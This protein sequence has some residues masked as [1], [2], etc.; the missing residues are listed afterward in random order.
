MK[1]GAALAFAL[2]ACTPAARRPADATPAAPEPVRPP[3]FV[4]GGNVAP[5]APL[6]ADQ[7]RWVDETMARLSPRERVAQ[8]V[9]VWVLGDYTNA[10]DPGM[11][12]VA[13][14]ITEDHIGGV[15]MSL[16]SPIEVAA[17]VNWMQ[18][19]S[20]V[21]LLV[22]SDVEPGLGRLEGGVF[23]PN[24]MRGGSATVLP[25]NM[26]IGAT[27]RDT[28]AF[29][30]GRITGLEARAIGIH[31]AFAPTADV[32]NNPSNPVINVR[33]FG[34]DPQAVA[35][36]VAAFVRGAQGEGIATTLKH[37]PGHGDTDTDSHNA[38]PVVQS[39]R[40][41]LEAV[42]LVPFRAGIAAGTAAVMSAHIALPG[43]AG[44]STTPATL[45]PQVM[46]GLLRD[47]LGFR[48]LIATDALTMEGV[49]KGYTAAQ[50]AVLALVAG[51]DMLEK[52]ADARQ[53]I[54]AVMDA[55]ARGVTT[56]ARVDSSA[57][58]ILELKARTNAA[59][60]PIVDLDSLRAV[61][62]RPEHLATAARIAQEA[63]TLLRDSAGLLPL[64]GRVAVVT[65][66]PELE[67]T[68]GRAFAAAM[69]AGLPG[70]RAF[71][72]SPRS[73]AGEL[74]TLARQLERFDRVVVTTHVRTIEGEGRFAIPAHIGAWI[75]SLATRGRLVVVANG[76]PYVIRQFPRVQSYVATFGIGEALER[77]AARALLGQAPITGRAPISLPGIFQ[78]G[79][80]LP[81][82]VT[83]R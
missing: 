81:R 48:G 3:A 31:L 63:I 56:Q 64:T 70:T 32:N 15:L 69:N 42:E 49:G 17:K 33:S 25:T 4:A 27:G 51:A 22:S 73:S 23:A 36:N 78:R 13:R 9:T 66:A 52:P 40:A 58:K 43:L 54:E 44:D 68:A 74:D 5:D 34:E 12:Q 24:L 38:L 76:N 7:Q 75:D 1:V 21:P 37:F 47:T 46:T 61:V 65:Y 62:A 19:L 79:D 35:R 71:R 29:E 50:S 18:R 57:R 16:G 45:A 59:A 28:N 67:I 11:Q 77:A 55:I 83:T 10:D 6:T 14:W 39:D 82:E 53:T 20:P 8:L 41:R 30:A 26:A 80:G 60:R 2:L 72:I